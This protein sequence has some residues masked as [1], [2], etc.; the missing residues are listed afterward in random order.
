MIKE[1]ET[2]MDK[3]VLLESNA[4]VRF[5]RVDNNRENKKEE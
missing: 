3:T 2:R 1:G 5:E 4:G